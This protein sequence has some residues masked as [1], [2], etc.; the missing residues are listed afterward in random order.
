LPSATTDAGTRCRL[1]F[2]L[3]VG[4]ESC[5]EIVFLLE[6]VCRNCGFMAWPIHLV[7]VNASGE[8]HG[9][10]GSVSPWC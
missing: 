4:L 1:I 10:L 6:H 2:V 5:G 8:M 9:A 3:V 7:G